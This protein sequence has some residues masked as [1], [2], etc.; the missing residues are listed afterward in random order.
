MSTRSLS[1][2]HSLGL[3][4]ILSRI[5]TV[6]RRNRPGNGTHTQHASHRVLYSTRGVPS[7]T[8]NDCA[9]LSTVIT[10]LVSAAVVSFLIRGRVCD[11][12]YIAQSS[13]AV[14]G[15]RLSGDFHFSA[16][17]VTSAVLEIPECRSCDIL[18]ECSVNVRTRRSVLKGYILY[19]DGE[20]IIIAF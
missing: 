16:E 14:I 12:A 2:S 6:S 4:L 1:Q 9:A 13:C 18:E 11:I 19:D 5:I 7:E 17:T 3:S 20:R 15:G 10:C 8:N